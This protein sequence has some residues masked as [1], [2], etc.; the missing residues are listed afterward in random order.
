MA[1]WCGPRHCSPP[2]TSRDFL[3][4]LHRLQAEVELQAGD[5][6][7]ARREA[8]TSLDLARELALPGEEGSTLRVLGELSR[9]DGDLP[10]AETLLRASHARQREVG[11]AYEEGRSLL[12]LA[13]VHAAHGRTGDALASLDAALPTFE[14]LSAQHDLTLART[15]R[16]SLA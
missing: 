15:L 8:Q 3:P 10:R 13:R 14:R 6:A 7:A 1:A 11:D 2:R 9:I 12:A 16:G 5:V 4:E